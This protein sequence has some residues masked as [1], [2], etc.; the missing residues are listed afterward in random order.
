MLLDDARQEVIPEWLTAV[1]PLPA[2][3]RSRLGITRLESL[4]GGWK[5][6]GG[7][8]GRGRKGVKGERRAEG[9]RLVEGEREGQGGDKEGRERQGGRE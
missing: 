2:V 3:R 8:E 6:G 4:R 9:E 1:L 5:D 7:K